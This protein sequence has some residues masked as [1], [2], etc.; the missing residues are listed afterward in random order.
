MIVYSNSCSFGAPAPDHPVYSEIVASG[1]GA[2]LI[3]NGKNNS[4]NRRIIRTAL[5]DLLELK[6][7]DNILVLLG[8]TVL[9]RTELWQPNL[10]VYRNDG[11]FQT[12]TVDHK[13]VNWSEQ[14][15]DTVVPNISDLAPA[16]IRD[17]YKHWLLHY[18]PEA[19]VTNVLTDLIMFCGWA[20]ANNINYV[21]FS[22]MDVLPR[23]NK[24]GYDSPFLSSLKSTIE[25]DTGIV[26]LWNFSF[27]G[28]A[29][30]HNLQPKD[31]HL[32]KQHGH[33]GAEAHK[34]FAE[35]LLTH[36]NISA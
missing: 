1:L 5:R 13:K 18:N 32:Y 7:Q 11:H 20:K 10:P 29:L 24:V 2:Q 12:I 26:D 23:S 19:E 9:T 25:Q 4:C 6:N 8:L 17:Y 16:D 3:N 36:K 31:Y 15:L 33:P 28:F 27:A 22:N 34:L 30:S 14:G 21:V 35:F